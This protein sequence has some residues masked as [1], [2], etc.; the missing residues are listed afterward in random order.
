MH[1]YIF[2]LSCSEKIYSFGNEFFH[3]I[4]DSNLSYHSNELFEIAI[5][6]YNSILFD[7][8]NYAHDAQ[9]VLTY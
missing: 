2:Q 4:Q 8:I 1:P 5:F 7:I 9:F 3:S 6:R